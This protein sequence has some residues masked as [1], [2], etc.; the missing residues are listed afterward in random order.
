MKKELG[1]LL[2][3]FLAV[4]DFQYIKQWHLENHLKERRPDTTMKT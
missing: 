3:D 4:S 1:Y 2:R